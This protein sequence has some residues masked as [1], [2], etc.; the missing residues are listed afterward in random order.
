VTRLHPLVA[1]VNHSTVV[2]DADLA[3]AMRALQHQALYHYE[4]HWGNSATLV[5]AEDAIPGAWL[6]LILDDSDQAGALGYHD[7]DPGTP[8]GKVFAK[9]DQKYGLSWTVTA[10]HELLEMLAD[11]D[12]S[13]CYQT[14]NTRFHAL[15]VG[16]PVEADADGY[17]I[18]N[19]LV[20]NFVLPSWFGQG[21][22]YPYDFCRQLEEPLTLRPGGYES[23]WLDGSWRQKDA[24][25]K[26]RVP[27][28]E[29][30]P[31]FRDRNQRSA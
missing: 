31:R 21:G 25:G 9:T 13:R 7:F 1:V 27:D 4:P 28:A 16:D 6:L 22:A 15:E 30:S 5:T 17:K 10:S 23:F 8:A 26:D 18:H 3:V 24:E 2:S 19:V 20:S 11:P 12:V 14:G 29:D